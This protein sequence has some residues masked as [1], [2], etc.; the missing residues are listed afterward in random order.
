MDDD[1][2][3]EAARRRDEAARLRDEEDR[4]LFAIRRLEDD[5]AAEA[6]DMEDRLAGLRDD[7]ARAEREIVDEERREH[8]GHEP[9]H[10]PGWPGDGAGRPPAHRRSGRSRSG[11]SGP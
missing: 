5:M 1:A 6:R 9:G 8:W 2:R 3:D 10:V 11:R 4:D 7:E